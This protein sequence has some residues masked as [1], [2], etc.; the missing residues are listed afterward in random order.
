MH[1]LVQRLTPEKIA[2]ALLGFYAPHK[3]TSAT[4]PRAELVEFGKF[5]GPFRC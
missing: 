1:D 4:L 3:P 5:T 2:S